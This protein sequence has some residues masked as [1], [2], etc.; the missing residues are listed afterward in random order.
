MNNKVFKP[1]SLLILFSLILLLLSLFY[2]VF[3]IKDEYFPYYENID[4]VSENGQ[5]LDIYI[6]DFTKENCDIKYCILN[7]CDISLSLDCEK[8]DKNEFDKPDMYKIVLDF[9]QYFP[10]I[11]KRRYLNSWSVLKV[12]NSN[13]NIRDTYLGSIKDI[14]EIRKLRDSQS[15]VL[16]F[17]DSAIDNWGCTGKDFITHEYLKSIYLLHSLGYKLQEPELI[18]YAEEEVI[19]LNSNISEVLN[20]ETEYPE[21]YILKLVDIGLDRRYLSLIEEYEIPSYK[22]VGLQDKSKYPIQT[23]FEES[24]SNKYIQIRRFTDYSKTFYEYE[25]DT[26]GDYFYNLAI[27]EYNATPYSLLGLCSIKNVKKDD[28]SN[29]IIIDMLQKA[30]NSRKEDFFVKNFFEISECMNYLRDSEY[31]QL[32]LTTIF[33]NSLKSS[34]FISENRSYFLEAQEFNRSGKTEEIDLLYYY[35]IKENLEILEFL[36]Y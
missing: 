35:R 30:E 26:L 34:S 15:C 2:L 10:E 12:S 27:E 9:K 8:I 22:K 1:I 23:D 24:L 18:K 28:L 17:Q 29:Q 6:T 33:K 21:A 13:D 5:L 16:P 32:D 7:K 19:Y 11:L 25:K 36:F 31:T 4:F 14:L 3:I 20:T